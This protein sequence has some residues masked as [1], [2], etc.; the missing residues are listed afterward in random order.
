VRLYSGAPVLPA[1]AL[2]DMDEGR[3]GPEREPAARVDPGGG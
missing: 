3:K 2:V 1:P